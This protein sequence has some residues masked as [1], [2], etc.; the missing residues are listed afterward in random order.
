MM[1]HG[2]HGMSAQRVN[3]AFPALTRELP[4]TSIP[5]PYLLAVGTPTPLK[6]ATPSRRPLGYAQMGVPHK[7][8]HPLLFRTKRGAGG[9]VFEKLPRTKAAHA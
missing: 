3:G 9:R 5:R 7:R 4:H 8:P 1:M 6:H 2:I